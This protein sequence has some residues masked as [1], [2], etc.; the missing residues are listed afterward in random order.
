MDVD[1]T[2]SSNEQMDVDNGLGS[3]DQGPIISRRSQSS[4]ETR[5]SSACPSPLGSHRVWGQLDLLD[6]DENLGGLIGSDTPLLRQSR[7][8]FG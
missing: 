3:V 6:E 2:G 4:A 1:L 7:R 5:N 8:E